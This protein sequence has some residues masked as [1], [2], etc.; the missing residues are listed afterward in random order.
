MASGG[1]S[2]HPMKVP[3]NCKPGTGIQLTAHDC[4][5]VQVTVPEGVEPGQVFN[6]KPGTIKV[7]RRFE[8][9]GGWR[10]S[11]SEVGNCSGIHWEITCCAPCFIAKTLAILRTGNA[12]AKYYVLN[13][14]C[15]NCCSND[16][17][18]CT[19]CIAGW[20]HN[21]CG[22]LCWQYSPTEGL[23]FTKFYKD[24]RELLEIPHEESS[25]CFK[26]LCENHGSHRD[27]GQIYLE[28]RTRAKLTVDPS[29]ANDD[30]VRIDNNKLVERLI[31]QEQDYKKEQGEFLVAANDAPE[32]PMMSRT[33]YVVQLAQ[34]EVQ[35][36]S[37]PTV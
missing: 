19:L 28:L 4:P 34:P 1:A 9:G 25:F 14:P 36:Q 35:P 33:P 2:G 5:G 30:I 11:Q 24:V 26:C 22:P 18:A 12:N 10:H 3:K 13:I 6:V 31:Q 15:R 7:L 32:T 21:M 29:A 27:V 17:T 20:P 23:G 37:D 16:K 8:A